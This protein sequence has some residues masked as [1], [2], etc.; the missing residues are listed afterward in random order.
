MRALVHLAYGEKIPDCTKC[1]GEPRLRP[2]YG[3]DEPAYAACN[4]HGQNAACGY[5]AGTGKAPL[6]VLAVTCSA[7]GGLGCERCKDGARDL[8]RCPGKL[9]ETTHGGRQVETAFWYAAQFAERS[10]LPAP[11][12]LSEQSATWVQ[13]LRVYEHERGAIMRE[14][15]EEERKAAERASKRR[16][17]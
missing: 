17:F 5:C 14:R 9:V 1:R 6:S 4:C 12:G 3:C 13:A 16:T 11:G 7:C 10:V 2:G 8:R 15:A